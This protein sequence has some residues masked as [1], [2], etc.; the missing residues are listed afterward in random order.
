MNLKAEDL[1]GKI[2]LTW[3]TGESGSYPVKEYD[4]FRSKGDTISDAIFIGSVN[5][6][7][8]T[9]T[10]SGPLERIPYYYWVIVVD[11]MGNSSEPGGHVKI[12]PIVFSNTFPT[13]IKLEF[14]IGKP[15]VYINGI[16]MKMEVAP[17][18]TDGRTFVPV[19]YV[20]EPFG[21]QVIWNGSER[22]VTLI[23]KKLIELWIG[24]SQAIVDSIPVYIDPQNLDV[25]PFIMEGRT[26]LPLRF[27]SETFGATVTWDSVA[28]KVAIEY[29]N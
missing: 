16:I 10:D 4:I 1:I 27:V 6:N 22:K 26:F 17:F 14:Y 18:I 11:N 15:Y 13:T 12:Q 20:A 24:N 19:R 28:K 5:S 7:V 29:K 25:V 9:F 23:H 8:F 3:N 2:K 21:A